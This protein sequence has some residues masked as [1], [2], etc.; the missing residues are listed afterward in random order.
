MK[1]IIRRT[2]LAATLTSAFFI[3]MA[4]HDSAPA[5]QTDRLPS[6][7]QKVIHMTCPPFWGVDP[8][9]WCAEDMLCW[10]G[11]GADG[12]S[13]KAALRDWAH[14]MRLQGVQITRP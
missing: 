10:I 12:R 4:N 6:T 9:S 3:G 14:H 2:A 7:C 5:A 8:A 1:Y 11:S 13:D